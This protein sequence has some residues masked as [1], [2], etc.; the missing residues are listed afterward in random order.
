MANE[1]SDYLIIS[2]V[3]RVMPS[4]QCLAPVPIH[5]HRQNT[6]GFNQSAEIGKLV[7][8]SIGCKFTQDLLI[9]TVSTASQTELGRK[10]RRRIYGVFF[11]L[12]PYINHLW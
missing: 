4:V 5:W 8:A 3:S 7:V 1:I 2:L 9:K 11:P 12:I 10:D 6:R